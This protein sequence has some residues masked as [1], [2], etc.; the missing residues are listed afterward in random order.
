MG[1]STSPPTPPAIDVG[2]EKDCPQRLTTVVSGPA[3]AGISKGTWLQVSV[4]RTGGGP[5]VILTDDV[6]GVTVG[7]LAGVPNLALLIRCLDDGVSYRALV[8]N[9]DGGRIDVTVLQE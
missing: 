4:D 6:T 9:V 1:G 7:S 5:R 3:A 8:D 2:P